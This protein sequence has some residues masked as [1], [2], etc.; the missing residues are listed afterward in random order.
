MRIAE[1]RIEREAPPFII[2]ELGVNHDGDVNRALELVDA[3]S[4]A[5]ADAVKLQYFEA[6]RLVSRTTQ[7]TGYQKRRGEDNALDMLRR[8]EL[9][10]GEMR[11]VIDRAHAHGLAAIVTV[12]SIELVEP[13][14]QLPWDAWKIASPDIV[15]RPLINAVMTTGS[16]LLV[17][18]GAATL[19]EVRQATKWL[20]NY[21]HV[22]MQCVSAYPTPDECAALA[23]RQAMEAVNPNALGYSDHTTSTLTGAYAVASGARVLEKHLTCDRNAT[24]PDHAASLDGNQFSEYVQ[25]AQEAFAMLGP[26]VKH[27]MDIERDVRELSRQSLVASSD[28]EAGAV[29][30]RSNLTIKRPG[31]GIAPAEL[32][33]L[34]GRTV[35]KRID[36]DT[37][38]TPDLVQ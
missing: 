23:G 34:I 30:Q 9:S 25:R 16:P 36:A 14:A 13:A 28:L 15:N 8:L 37:P 2:A 7:L 31:T 33:H 29:L 10:L 17:S 12:F 26:S 38:L 1:T 22:L 4:H 35:T 18:T 27:V 32:E 19:D 21:A 24:G 3:A 11:A 6:E 5:R 20:T